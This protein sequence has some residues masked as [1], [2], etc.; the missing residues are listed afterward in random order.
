MALSVTLS[1]GA[2][3]ASWHICH[4]LSSLI[5]KANLAIVMRV[6]PHTSVDHISPMAGPI[7]ICIYVCMC[8][9][10]ICVCVRDLFVC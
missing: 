1:G 10:H 9:I 5:V 8:I 6:S 2:L 3:F 7:H 4:F